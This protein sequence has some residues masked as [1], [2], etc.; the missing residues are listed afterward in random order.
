M[1]YIGQKVVCVKSYGTDPRLIEGQI[2]RVLDI[3]SC[4]SV[5]NLDVGLTHS[6]GT[7]CLRCYKERLD[8]I[9]WVNSVQFAPLEENKEHNKALE[10]LFKELDLQVN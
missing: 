8:G 2:Y 10:Q 1:Y 5:I 4:C 7:H 9:Q 3:W 6:V